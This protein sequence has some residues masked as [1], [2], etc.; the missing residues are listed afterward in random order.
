[1]EFEAP[2]PPKLTAILKRLRRGREG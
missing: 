1:V 2:L